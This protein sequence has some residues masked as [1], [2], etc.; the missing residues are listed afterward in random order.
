MGSRMVPFERA[1]V[2]SYRPSIVTF[3]LSLRVSEILSSRTP[4]FPTPPLVSPK[5]PHVPLGVAGSPSTYEE[6]RCCINCLCNYF[7]RFPA[8]VTTIHQ[9]FRRTDRRTT[10]VR[11]PAF[12]WVHYQHAQNDGARYHRRLIPLL[13]RSSSRLSIARTATR[14]TRLTTSKT[15]STQLKAGNAIARPR[16]ALKCIAR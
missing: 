6:R 15:D 16:F 12:S 8:Y 11:D 2:T 7:P 3:P 14:Q 10:L 13:L 4:L 9:H 1:L 5:F